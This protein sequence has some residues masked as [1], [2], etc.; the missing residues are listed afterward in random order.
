MSKVTVTLEFNNAEEARRFFAQQPPLTESSASA[1]RT[2]PAVPTPAST[3]VPSAPASAT[4]ADSTSISTAPVPTTVSAPA[5]A[6][7]A[8]ERPAYRT[9]VAKAI[10]GCASRFPSGQGAVKVRAILDAHG[11]AKGGDV[12]PENA[13]ALIA[14]FDTAA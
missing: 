7:V 13:Q 3:I 2:A 1:S 4:L 11:L 5:T 8:G 10:S 9:A 14:A 6:P 12:K